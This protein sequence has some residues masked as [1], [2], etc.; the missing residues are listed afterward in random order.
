MHMCD[1]SHSYMRLNSFIC[2]TR[3]IHMC[4]MSHSCS[5][6]KMHWMP[7]IAGLS[8]QK[9]HELQGFFA[10]NDL[11]F[12]RRATNYRALL[13]KM[14]YEDKT[15]YDS[16]PLYTVNPKSTKDPVKRNKT[17]SIC[18]KRVFE[19]S[20]GESF[21]LIESKVPSRSRNLQILF[22]KTTEDFW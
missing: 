1:V 5:V 8:P 16:T 12:R 10:E 14:T 11:F 20:G 15:S 6:A 2:M 21:V 13:Q 18:I 9:S 19:N 7:E 17:M 22:S 4:D 3:L